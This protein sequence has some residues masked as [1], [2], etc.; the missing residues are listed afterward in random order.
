MI[1]GENENGRTGTS[2]GGSNGNGGEIEMKSIVR[3][4]EMLER[5]FLPRPRTA[6]ARKLHERLVAAKQRV[7]DWRIAAGIPEPSDEG[8]PPKK[9]HTSQGIQLIRD[10]LNEG[11]S[12]SRL[13]SIRDGILRPSDRPAQN[14]GS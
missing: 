2:Q 10:I 7:R 9:V 3:R 13:R 6:S 8:L 11:R 5:R 14:G 1:A 4:I 12:R